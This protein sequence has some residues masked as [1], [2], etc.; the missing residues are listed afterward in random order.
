MRSYAESTVRNFNLGFSS[1]AQ[2]NSDEALLFTTPRNRVRIEFSSDSSV[3]R[4]GFFANFIADFDECQN[5]N[6]GC[7]HT[8]QNRLGK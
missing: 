7:E 3:E 5:D 2:K 8:C 6:A 4:D 1:Y